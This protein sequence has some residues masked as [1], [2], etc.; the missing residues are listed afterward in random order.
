MILLHYLKKL[1]RN[2]SMRFVHS[3]NTQPM[4][5]DIYGVDALKRLLGQ[6]IYYA[7]SV[8]YLKKLGHEIVMHTDTFGAKLI[9]DIPYDEVY[10]TLDN[11][12][13][14]IHPRFWAAGKIF[15]QEAEPLGSVHI[16]GD[17]FIKRNS[18]VKMLEKSDWD[19]LTQNLEYSIQWMSNKVG[20]QPIY[21]RRKEL[22]LEPFG[23]DLN[24]PNT[25]NCGVVGF[26][27]QELKDKYIENYKKAA[28][29]ISSKLWDT[30]SNNNST[31]DF[32]VEQ[33]L[34]YH[35]SKGYK[36][37]FVLSDVNRDKEIATEI[38]FQHTL[39]MAKFNHL[40]QCMEILKVLDFELYNK[41]YKLCR[42]ILKT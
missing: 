37:G 13:K 33:Q 36:A 7:T 26:R 20:L 22:L 18:L 12:P 25:F 9:Q 35:L 39:S 24:E 15:A 29:L 41:I 8:A 34:L 32:I 4:F 42:N 5:I 1:R 2:K 11:M 30:L 28:R 10:L 21:D 6:V 3:F 31:P 40:E 14:D 27:N 16:D 17:V 38:G 23:L 19:V